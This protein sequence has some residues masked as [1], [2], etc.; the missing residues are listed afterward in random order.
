MKYCIKNNTRDLQ[1]QATTNFNIFNIVCFEFIFHS[2][3]SFDDT[4]F[5]VPDLQSSYVKLSIK[6]PSNEL[7]W[8]QG[9]TQDKQNPSQA[10]SK[11]HLTELLI[12]HRRKWRDKRPV[13]RSFKLNHV[14]SWMRIYR[15]LCCYIILNFR[16]CAFN[17]GTLNSS[18]HSEEYRD[19]AISRILWRPKRNRLHKLC[20]IVYVCML[21]YYWSL[22]IHLWWCHGGLMQISIVHHSTSEQ[23]TQIYS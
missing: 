4:V 10:H 7:W 21:L 6:Y 11:Q 14:K 23:K 13:M 9:W 22:Y 17:K 12:S 3:A 16:C 15:K 20:L 5:V 2:N 18:F 1:W 8:L 19:Q